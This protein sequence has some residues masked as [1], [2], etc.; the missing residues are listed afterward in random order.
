VEIFLA[1]IFICSNK[2]CDFLQSVDTFP[3]EAQCLRSVALE[4][5]RLKSKLPDA[6][7]ESTCLVVSFKGA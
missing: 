4:T 5:A 1:V 3:T 7:M 2:S 6:V